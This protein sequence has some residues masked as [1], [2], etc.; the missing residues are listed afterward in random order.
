MRPCD[1][2]CPPREGTGEGTDRSVTDRSIPR[3]RR[4]GRS[5]PPSVSTAA[6]APTGLA[7]FHAWSSHAATAWPVSQTRRLERLVEGHRYVGAPE[8]VADNIV[9]DLLT[10]VMGWPIGA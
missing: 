4:P 6:T 1:A 10:G 7:S 5:I 9:E 8:Q 3:R 2:L